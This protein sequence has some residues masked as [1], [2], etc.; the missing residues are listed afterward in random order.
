MAF[1][2]RSQAAPHLGAGSI[3]EQHDP[4]VHPARDV[5]RPGGQRQLL[6][7]APEEPGDQLAT[8]LKEQVPLRPRLHPPVRGV[9]VEVPHQRM[10]IGGA[11]ARSVQF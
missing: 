10:Q 5:Q 4:A 2:V 7:T 3:E 8:G 1:R 6:Q 11:E 9:L